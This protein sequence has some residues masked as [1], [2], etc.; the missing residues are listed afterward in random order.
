MV[1]FS[2][3]YQNSTLD[4][5][6]MHLTNYSINKKNEMFVKIEDVC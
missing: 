3:Y 4:N 1:I 5:L 2:M 6:C